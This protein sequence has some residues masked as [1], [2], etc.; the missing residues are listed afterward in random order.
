MAVNIYY[1][2]VRIGNGTKYDDSENNDVEETETF[3]GVILDPGISKYEFTISRV[4]SDDPK[5][6][7]IIEN[8]LKK[9]GGPLTVEDTVAKYRDYYT[10]CFVTS[11]KGSKD[12][13]KRRAEDITFKAK[14]R[15]RKWG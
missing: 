9:N 13:R 2:G 12:P 15:T 14:S 10:Q 5:Y 3:D 11:R 6:E 1:N 8:V 7:D 4:V